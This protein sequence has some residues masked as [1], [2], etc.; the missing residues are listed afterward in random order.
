MDDPDSGGVLGTAVS[1]GCAAATIVFVAGPAAGGVPGV[2]RIGGGWCRLYLV[3]RETHGLKGVRVSN[4]Q[5][6]DTRIGFEY[7]PF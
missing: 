2:V 7:V 4:I 1:A 6:S 5:R 3:S